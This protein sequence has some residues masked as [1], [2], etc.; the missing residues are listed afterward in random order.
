MFLLDGE[1][2]EKKSSA[3]FLDPDKIERTLFQIDEKTKA[4]H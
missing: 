3:S 2:A 1:A 4:K